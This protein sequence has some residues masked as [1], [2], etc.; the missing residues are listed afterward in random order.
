VKDF[1]TQG[2]QGVETIFQI[3]GLQTLEEVNDGIGDAKSPGLGQLFDAMGMNQGNRPFLPMIAGVGL[4]R[5]PLTILRRSR[6][7]LSKNRLNGPPWGG[8]LGGQV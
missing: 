6:S 1:V 2:A 7:R 8:W 5:T 4:L 3:A